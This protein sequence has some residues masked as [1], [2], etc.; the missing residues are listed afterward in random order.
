MNDGKTV[1]GI[2]TVATH[3]PDLALPFITHAGRAIDRRELDHAPA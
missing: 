1:S 2:T 3:H